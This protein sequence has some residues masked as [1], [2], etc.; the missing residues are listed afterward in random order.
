MQVNRQ[1]HEWL[2][3]INNKS[4]S[5][6]SI[7]NTE[8]KVNN[9]SKNSSDTIKFSKKSRTSTDGQVKK[10]LANYTKL[11][12]YSKTETE[13]IAIKKQRLPCAVALV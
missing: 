1:L 11:K 13:K 4:D 12:V 8:E 3:T 5:T 2:E 9:N 10:K 7:L 6:N